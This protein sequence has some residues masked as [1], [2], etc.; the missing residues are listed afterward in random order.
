MT[1]IHTWL[2]KETFLHSLYAISLVVYPQTTS[3]FL[4]LLYLFSFYSVSVLFHLGCWDFFFLSPRKHFLSQMLSVSPG[5]LQ[6]PN[7]RWHLKYTSAPVSCCFPRPSLRTVIECGFPSIPEPHVQM[8][9]PHFH[10]FTQKCHTSDGSSSISLCFD[11]P[12]TMP[13][14]QT[15]HFSLEQHT[16]TRHQKQV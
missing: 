11:T 14:T 12:G 13:P 7:S 2:K 16:E 9:A 3:F 5:N 8:C 1:H 6:L 4:F 10:I 15:P